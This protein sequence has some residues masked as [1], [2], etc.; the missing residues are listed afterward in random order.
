MKTY[1]GVEELDHAVGKLEMKLATRTYNISHRA[2][3]RWNSSC[4]GGGACVSFRARCGVA[5]VRWFSS[6]DTKSGN[7][8]TEQQTWSSKLRTKWNSW[9]PRK[10]E[11]DWTLEL[12]RKFAPS[13]IDFVVTSLSQLEKAL[14]GKW[15]YED[16]TIGLVALG[17]MREQQKKRKPPYGTQV[18][19]SN[20]LS[21]NQD[22]V[23]CKLIVVRRKIPVPS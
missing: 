4:I 15:T 16:L 11:E 5:T 19:A 3:T 18:D 2:I 10:K 8:V 6:N 21:L 22:V 7:E 13:G 17:R 23:R 1:C 14:G 12:I 20:S 9:I